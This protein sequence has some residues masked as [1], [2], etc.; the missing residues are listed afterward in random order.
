MKPTE[1]N[2]DSMTAGKKGGGGWDTPIDRDLGVTITGLVC[3]REDEWLDNRLLFYTI[4]TTKLH[5]KPG[6]K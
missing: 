3:S 6:I 1:G 5:K 2:S 4:L